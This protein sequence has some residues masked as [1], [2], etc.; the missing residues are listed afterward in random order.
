MNSKAKAASRGPKKDHGP[1]S[2]STGQDPQ[3]P[4]RRYQRM[5][6][7]DLAYEQIED[8]IVSCRLKPGQY[9]TTQDLQDSTGL[10][11]TPVHQAVSRLAADTIILV[12]P[13][14]GLQI[15]TVDLERERVLLRLRADIERFVIRLATERSDRP[16]QNT[17]C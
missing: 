7:F 3:A 14:H 4:D 5:N 16:R 11:R 8:L 15:A 1:Q 9:L 6:L 17:M 13:R 2:N 10:G 12:R